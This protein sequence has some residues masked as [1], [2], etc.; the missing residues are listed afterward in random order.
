MFVRSWMSA[1]AVVI[2]PTETVRA[3]DVVMDLHKVRRLLV[4][5]NGRLVGIVTRTDLA[6]AGNREKRVGDVMAQS[7]YQVAPDETLE[8]AAK[9]MFANK[10]SGLPVVEEGHVKGVITE[11]DVFRALVSMMGFGEPGA[12]VS[13]TVPEG[14]DVIAVIARKVEGRQLRSLV[15]WHDGPNNQWQVTIR[16]RGKEADERKRKASRQRDREVA[17]PE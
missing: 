8:G 7:P 6:A 14:E 16:M 10:I 5:E 2:A 11:S 1:P 3:A 17:S 13:L 9:L 12:R 4:V 15:T